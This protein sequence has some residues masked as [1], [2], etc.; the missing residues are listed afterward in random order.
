MTN[1]F[2]RKAQNALNHALIA[3]R[4]FGH[5]YVGSEHLLVGLASDSESVSA[6]IL[7]AKGATRAKIIDTIT[8]A[9]GTGTPTDVTAADLTPRTKQII[10][11][12]AYTSTRLGHSYIGTEH[13]LLSLLE[14]TDCVALR[15][16]E[17]LGVSA[18]DLKNSLLSYLDGVKPTAPVDKA[19]RTQARA[20]GALRDCP[21]LASYG[22]NLTAL[23][24]EGKLDPIIGRDAETERVIQ[25][26]AR[27]QKN[28]PCLIG[29]P[30]VGK[31]AVVEGLAKRIAD[32]NI[33]EMLRNKT[34]VTVD[35]PSMI[36]GAKYRGEFEERLKNVMAEVAKRPDIIL[37][38][39]EIHTLVGAGA[40][41]G[42][43]DAANIL[44][45]ALSRGEMQLIG[46]TTIAEYRKNIEKDA[47][48]ERRFQSVMV[49]E[50]SPE[51]AVRILRGLRDR[52]EA[53][54]KLKISDDAIE[55]AVSL[56]ARYINDRYLPDKA[57]D[58]VDEAASR[59]RISRYTS[60]PDV[61]ALEARVDTLCREK[62]EAI[63]AQDFEAAARLRDEEQALRDELRRE[64]T[65]WQEN[66]RDAAL[67]V[68]REDIADIVT[69]WTGIPVRQMESEESKKLLH[70]DKILKEHIIGQPEAVDAVAKAIR[71]GRMGLKDP[72]RPLGSFL[73]LG[74]TGVGK[75]ELCRALALVMFGDRNAIIRVDMSEYMEKHS[76]SRLIGSPPGYVGYDEGGQLTEKIRRKPYSV[77]LFD[78]V[79]KAHPDVLN[80]LLQILDDGMLTDAQ[81]RR[82][83]FKNTVIILTSNIGASAITEK[84]KSLGFTAAATDEKAAMEANVMQALKSAFRPEFLNRLDEIIVF[85]RLTD[86]DIRKIASLLLAELGERICGIGVEIEF[87]PSLVAYVAEKGFDPI[88]GAR[89]L[90]RA[91]TSLVEDSF[92]EAMLEGRIAAG[93]RI[94]AKAIEG[95]VLFEKQ[96]APLP[97]AVG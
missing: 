10:E 38:I 84:A 8:T 77:V 60:P 85:N 50:P 33:P 69:A 19:A 58:L 82:V 1:R 29:E 44:K 73:F 5:S 70:L 32:G 78:E 13:L 66:R 42:A 51:D 48:L 28:N 91:I 62:E 23:A 27:R 15:V 57:I 83:D 47:A 43:L 86:A 79:E 37:F 71:R 17:A 68:T 12:S 7:A 41:E 35:I 21:T 39:D 93:D 64:T 24:K 97:D 88:Y 80:I 18:T 52:Y 9:I 14:E 26:L 65:A 55:A 54:H 96:T 22:R 6:R 25:I 11:M 72:K 3:A 31:T 87:D 92:S 56:S 89:P 94:L 95:K 4:S 20:D 2:T 67:T 36:A 49:G 40:A 90:R 30:G 63:K 45:P 75:T 34:I 59:L 74:P 61:K 81:G 46:A 53:H 16:L 76:V